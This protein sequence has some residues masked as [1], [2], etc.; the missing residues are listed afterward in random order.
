MAHKTKTGAVRR[1]R[2]SDFSTMQL[3]GPITAT[4]TMITHCYDDDATVHRTR[5]WAS[6][7]RGRQ[8]QG[9][10]NTAGMRALALRTLDK[11]AVREPSVSLV[12]DLSA[13]LAA[14]TD[15]IASGA[16]CFI[17]GITRFP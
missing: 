4:A 16:R 3:V 9:Y 17:Y 11:T 7:T 13:C 15:V 10:M 14:L 1:W 5:N 6:H 8:E 2:R 12:G